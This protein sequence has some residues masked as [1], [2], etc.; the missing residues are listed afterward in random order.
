MRRDDAAGHRRVSTSTVVEAEGSRRLTRRGLAGAA[1]AALGLGAQRAAAASDLPL[2]LSGQ[3]VQGGFLVG[4]TVP[5]AAIEL[6]GE[7]V[8]RASAGGVFVVGFDRDAAAQARIGVVA[9]GRRTVRQAAVA[10][11]V[12]DVQR[13]NGLKGDQVSPADPA[14]LRRIAAEGTIKARGWRSRTEAAH[15]ESGFSPPVAARTSASFGGQ[16]ILNGQ[17][18]RPH[19][20]VDLAAPRG[21]PVRAPAGGRVALA[22]PNLHFEGGLVL[23]DHGQG[24]VAAFLH[25]SR[26]DV[27]AGQQ[28]AKGAVIGAVGA[29]GRATGPHLCWRLKWRGRNMDPSLWL[30]PWRRV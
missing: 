23:I 7:P 14:L 8:G 1:G 11:G 20:G 2:E 18:K 6:D 19:Y 22:E 27:Q 5:L 17:P 4:R 29:T 26:V 24:L 21:T 15:F 25:L 3:P 13:I 9:D 30:R 12:F 10:R 16:R 28:V